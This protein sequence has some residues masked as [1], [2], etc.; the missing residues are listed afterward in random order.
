[1]SAAQ[2][3]CKKLAYMLKSAAD[4]SEGKAQQALSLLREYVNPMVAQQPNHQEKRTKRI[5]KCGGLT[6]HVQYEKGDMRHGKELPVAYGYIAASH[7]LDGDGIDVFVGPKPTQKFGTIFVIRQMRN[8]VYDE[9][10]VMLGFDNF[11]EA[12][13][14]YLDMY[15]SRFF[16]GIAWFSQGDFERAVKETQCCPQ[17][18][19]GW[20]E[21]SLREMAQQA[22]ETYPWAS[23]DPSQPAQI[24]PTVEMPD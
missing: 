17:P 4:M 7:A 1:M 23:A 14:C 24:V 19:G 12:K 3:Q 2:D 9:D 21:W 5:F 20:D 18:L 10:K 15:P 8:G 16:G 6:I 11:E 22:P 13:A